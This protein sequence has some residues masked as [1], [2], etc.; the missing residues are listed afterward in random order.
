MDTLAEMTTRG[1]GLAL[2]RGEACTWV[3][4]L[5]VLGVEGRVAGVAGFAAGLVARVDG[6]RVDGVAVAVP[7]AGFAC[8]TAAWGAS[9]TRIVRSGTARAVVATWI[10]QAAEATPSVMVD[11]ASAS[12]TRDTPRSAPLHRDPTPT[13]YDG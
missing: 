13:G 10:A 1:V 3:R 8:P 9:T 11:T 2:G 6:V 4:A 7:L 5:L 12:A